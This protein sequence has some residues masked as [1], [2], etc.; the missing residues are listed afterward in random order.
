MK[1][2]GGPNLWGLHRV[3]SLEGKKICMLSSGC[4]AVHSVVID[5]EGQ[6]YTWGRNSGCS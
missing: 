5:E 2:I 1:N 4:V 6:A 3:A